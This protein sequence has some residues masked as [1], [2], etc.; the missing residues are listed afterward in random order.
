MSKVIINPGGGGT[1]SDECTATKA[2]VLAG[3][4]AVTADSDDEAEE[5][6][7][8]VQSILSFRAAPYSSTQI[9]FTWQNPAKGAFSG[10]IIVGKVGSYPTS[11]TDGTRYYKGYG[12]NPAANGVSSMT[13]DG[14]SGGVTYYFRAFSYA[15]RNGAE[16]IS[17]KTYTAMASTTK[18]QQTFTSS[19]VF[20]VPEGVRSID[21]FCVG[22]GASGKNGTTGASSTNAGGGGGSG[23]TAIV[24]AISVAPGQQFAVTIGAGGA[25]DTTWSGNGGGATSFGELCVAA[26]GG[27]SASISAGGS[28][29]S[30]GGSSGGG[31]TY[32]SSRRGIGGVGGSDGSSGGVGA[33][34]IT[35]GAGQGTTTRAFGEP[36]NTLYAGGGAGGSYSNGS[37]YSAASGGAG[38]GGRGGYRISHDSS[39]DISPGQPGTPGTGGGGG[40]GTSYSSTSSA[41]AWCRQGGSG[42]SGICIVRWGY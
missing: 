9:I 4:K 20:T 34:A 13:V 29:G 12:N 33:S 24:K 16:W 37:T 14:F 38:G 15:L 42:G 41:Y 27:G 23:R 1:G 5:G 8:D 11:I 17:G 2:M 28:G 19:G 7:L 18:G 35:A 36:T 39:D 21:V 26:G 10:V 31:S 25:I 22:G 40:G 30:G 6:T 32:S 3:Y